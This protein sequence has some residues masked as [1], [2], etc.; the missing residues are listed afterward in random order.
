MTHTDIVQQFSTQLNEIADRTRRTETNLHKMREHFGI[1]GPNTQVKC[2]GA[3]DVI[4]QGYDVT[5]A[6]IK[7]AAVEA[8]H[9]L[10][11]RL[12]LHA[13][14]KPIAV[15]AFVQETST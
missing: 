7:K 11:D 15:I 10:G 6:Q 2:T 9:V 3:N 14:G 4:V 12:V 13:N 1:A 5:L 8:E